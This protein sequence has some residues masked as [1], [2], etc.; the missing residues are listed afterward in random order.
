MLD[1]RLAPRSHFPECS[2]A[3]KISLVGHGSVVH[4]I[5]LPSRALLGSLK[6]EELSITLERPLG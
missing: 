4:L 6:V 2:S 1:T 5:V 3:H